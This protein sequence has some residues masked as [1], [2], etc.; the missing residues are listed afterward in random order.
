[1]NDSMDAKD[2]RRVAPTCTYIYLYNLYIC[3]YIFV[4]TSKPSKSALAT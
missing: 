2:N 4:S 3:I 1:M